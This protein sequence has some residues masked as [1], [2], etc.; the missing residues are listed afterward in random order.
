MENIFNMYLTFLCSPA[1]DLDDK[2]ILSAIGK[3]LTAS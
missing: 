3:G 2:C 1:V